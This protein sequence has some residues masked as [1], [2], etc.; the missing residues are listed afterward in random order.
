MHIQDTMPSILRKM[1]PSVL[2]KKSFLSFY[3]LGRDILLAVMF[4]AGILYVDSWY[5]GFFLSIFLGMTLMGLFVLG[6]DAGHRSFSK[7]ERVN[8]FIGH[9]TTSFCLWPF[10]VWRLSHDLHHRHTHNLD[11]EIA[12]RPLTIKQYLRRSAFDRW[13]YRATRSYLMSISSIVFTSYFI[14]DALLG[15]RSK[16]FDQKDMPQLRRSIIICLAVTVGVIF[17]SYEVAGLYGLIN[18]FVLPQIVFQTLLSVFTF[19][20]HTSPDRTLY[21][22]V[23]WTMEK[24]QLGGTIHVK[25]PAIIEW[26]CHDINWHVPHH[27]CVGIPHYH[28]RLAH[29]NLKRAYPELVK[30]VELNVKTW[31][32]VTSKCHLVVGKE[33]GQETWVS[34]DQVKNYQERLAEA[35]AQ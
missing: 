25:Y 9:I 12:W 28:L 27:V 21:S 24:G 15:R 22:N 1:P 19:F 23:N 31:F 7:H 18:L 34:F 35:P 20:H 4:I 16:F 5:L 6:H 8:N 26:F 30:E 33:P 2:S 10:H 11:K 32:D 17:T 29:K 3:F 13:F 14:R